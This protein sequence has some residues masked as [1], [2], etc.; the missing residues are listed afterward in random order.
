MGKPDAVT[1]VCS[2][3]DI[4]VEKDTQGLTVLHLASLKGDE[5]VLIYIMYR[6]LGIIHGRKLC[7]FRESGSNH[8]CI[9]AFFIIAGIYIYEIA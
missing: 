9:L 5:Q 3:N 1:G 8:K 2:H 7:K 6:I 4:T